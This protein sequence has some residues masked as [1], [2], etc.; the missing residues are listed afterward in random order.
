MKFQPPSQPQ[1]ISLCDLL[2]DSYYH[3]LLNPQKMVYIGFSYVPSKISMAGYVKLCKVPEVCSLTWLERRVDY[4]HQGIERN[5]GRG[6]PCHHQ[7]AERLLGPVW[8]TLDGEKVVGS[9][10]TLFSQRRRRST[11]Y[12][13]NL[14]CW[15]GR[16][17]LSRTW[18][19]VVLW[20]RMELM[21]SLRSSLHL[22]SCPP[23]PIIRNIRNSPLLMLTTTSQMSTPPSRISSKLLSHSPSRYAR[24]WGVRFL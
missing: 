15:T 12:Y 22:I 5:K 21:K 3:R 2:I 1:R 24:P 9:L 18:S 4:Y 17:C 6:Y 23:L 8:I 16:L 20:W 13:L 14:V 11:T 10:F 19:G 7:E